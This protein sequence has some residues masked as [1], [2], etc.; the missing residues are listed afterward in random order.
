MVTEFRLTN[1][2]I[3]PIITPS[4]FLHISRFLDPSSGLLPSL[5]RLRIVHADT[6]LAYLHLLYTPS[7]KT[8]E[9][10]NIPDHQHPNFFSFL[11]TLIHK[12]PFL[13]HMIFGPGQFPLKSLQAIPKFAH[14]R[15]LELMDVASTFDLTFIQDVGALPNLECFMLDARSCKY[16]ASISE[17]QHKTLPTERTG[18][19]SQNL[20]L[21]SDI[22]NNGLS[23]SVYFSS[24]PI[25]EEDVRSGIPETSLCSN[26]AS[27]S[28]EAENTISEPLSGYEDKEVCD[29]S[30]PNYVTIPGD[31][32][33]STSTAGGFYQ[34]KKFHFVGGLP[35]IQD[36]I[37][38]IA[39]NTLEDISITVIRL[40]HQE[41]EQISEEKDKNVNQAE[42]EER[43]RKAE[44]EKQRRILEDELLNYRY[45]YRHQREEEI[46]KE[47]E[48]QWKDQ[49]AQIEK[50]LREERIQWA[51]ATFDLQTASYINVLQTVSSR[52]SEDLKSVK[53]NQLDRSLQ[54]PSKPPALTKQVYETL[55]C[56][57]KIEIL[58]FKRWK[59][60]SVEDFI[61]SKSSSP[62]NLKLLYLLIDDPDCCGVS[63]SSLLDIAKACP[64]FISLQLL[65]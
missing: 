30:E 26:Y 36:I 17:E 65:H 14:L 9:V 32:S 41:L 31:I 63:L 49:E 6:Y 48:D 12:S 64:M 5:L 11:T 52:W 56:H 3:Q 4:A 59:L 21:S 7:L 35:L 38:C 44:E 33:S 15:Q 24:S 13:E 45:Y 57:P 46:S 61:S 42:A 29:S 28:R 53:F 2:N 1:E 20:K 8:L 18:A 37:P 62:K 16:I 27:V 22:D 25:Y 50:R 19:G 51:Q 40:L 23:G 54:P 58:E 43:R 34:L 55:F 47:A 10:A 39:S 60:D